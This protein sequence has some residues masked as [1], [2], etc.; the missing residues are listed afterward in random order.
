MRANQ[1][2]ETCGSHGGREK[3][4]CEPNMR[5]DEVGDGDGQLAEDGR[6]RKAG[7]ER[8]QVA[9][10]G[11]ATLRVNMPMQEDAEHRAEDEAG[12]AED[13]RDD[14]ERRVVDL[15]PGEDRRR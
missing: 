2:K 12:D 11:A 4:V 9:A 10:V 8:E 3:T 5:R 7:D 6:G 1:V 13:D 15:R 14:A